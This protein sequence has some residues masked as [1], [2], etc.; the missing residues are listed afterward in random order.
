MTPHTHASRARGATA[1]DVLEAD[2]RWSPMAHCN[3]LDDSCQALPPL[4]DPRLVRRL[5]DPRIS[6]VGFIHLGSFTGQRFAV[7]TYA[8]PNHPALAAYDY[9][10]ST[11]WVSPLEDLPGWPR[12][13]PSGLLIARMG[14]RG[15]VPRRYVYAANPAEFVAYAEGG[16]RVWKRLS[17]EITPGAPDGVGIP[18]SI[19]F[20]DAREL[21]AATSKGWVV[22][23]DPV[24]GRP[25]DA[26]KMV[27]SVLVN[28]RV[29]RGTFITMKSPIVIGNVMYLLAEFKPDH[30]HAIAPAACPVYLV[31]IELTQPDVP[32]KEHSIRP[33]A[34]PAGQ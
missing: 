9:D 3:R 26:Y 14:H 19:S 7:C 10:G 11:L 13:I 2:G 12:R 16:A 33:L 22:K 20:N 5:E 24:D 32:G 4:R 6:P 34:T 23:L 1:V 25:I 31:R 15:Q 17:D 18:I 8:S 27:T 30:L 28:G 29:H 21:V